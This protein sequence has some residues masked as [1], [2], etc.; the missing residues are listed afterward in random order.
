MGGPARAKNFESS[1]SRQS[2]RPIK[3]GRIYETNSSSCRSLNN[4]IR[5]L[6]HGDFYVFRAANPDLPNIIP[7]AA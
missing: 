2:G 3:R 5:T 4:C 6:F 7:L 1:L